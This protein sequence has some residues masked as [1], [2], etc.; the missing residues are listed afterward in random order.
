MKDFHTPE[1]GRTQVRTSLGECLAAIAGL[2]SRIAT[3]LGRAAGRPPVERRTQVATDHPA[4][5]DTLAE[6]AH[7]EKKLAAAIARRDELITD[8]MAGEELPR[9]ME[10]YQ[11]LVLRVNAAWNDILAFDELLR[12]RHPAHSSIFNASG[13]HERVV[14][15]PSTDRS[16]VQPL[17][18]NARELFAAARKAADRFAEALAVD[19]DAEFAKSAK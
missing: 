11:A 13:P 18:I 2:Q 12:R 7:L 15:A 6:H 1:Q 16:P 8:V 5:N 3:G 17:E 19:A 10:A 14:L 9:R 4:Q